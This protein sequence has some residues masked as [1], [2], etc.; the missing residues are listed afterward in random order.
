LQVN[1]DL[2]EQNRMNVELTELY[3]IYDGDFLQ[4]VIY[5][6]RFFEVDTNYG[7]EWIE[8]ELIGKTTEPSKSELHDYIEGTR[9]YGCRL[10]DGY[11]AYLSAAGYLDRTELCV[12]ETEMEAIQ[13]LVELTL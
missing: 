2:K 3:E 12:F 4:P 8:Q 5:Q 1:L 10:I 13:Y 9:V 6:D 7:I 11:G